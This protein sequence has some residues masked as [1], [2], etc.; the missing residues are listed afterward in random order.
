MGLIDIYCKWDPIK[1]Q[2][3]YICI[4]AFQF[5]QHFISFVS[6]P[7]DGLKDRNRLPVINSITSEVVIDCI[8]K[9]VF[10]F[11]ITAVSILDIHTV[12]LL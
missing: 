8:Y 6:G 10:S 2:E 12:I 5:W 11:P 7:E 3:L 1:N 4:L 9:F